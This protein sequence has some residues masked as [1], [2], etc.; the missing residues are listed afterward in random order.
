MM[1]S[2]AKLTA[3]ILVTLLAASTAL[4][5][6]DYIRGSYGV[7]DIDDYSAFSAAPTLASFQKLPRSR[8][9]QYIIEAEL[10]M[11][12]GI[13]IAEKAVAAVYGEAK[14]TL[15]KD[16][17]WYADSEVLRGAW[18][19]STIGGDKVESLNQ[20]VFGD[21][22]NAVTNEK[23]EE[24]VCTLA[25]DT[26]NNSNMAVA[27]LSNKIVSFTSKNTVDTEAEDK[28]DSKISETRTALNRFEKIMKSQH[29]GVAQHANCDAY[30]GP[31]K[32]KTL[33]ELLSHSAANVSRAA[34][35][36][37]T[38]STQVKI[39]SAK[40]V[41]NAAQGKCTL[42]QIHDSLVDGERVLRN[43]QAN[44][45]KT[46]RSSNH[47]SFNQGSCRFLG[48]LERESKTGSLKLQ[49]RPYAPGDASTDQEGK[50]LN[51]LVKNIYSWQQAPAASAIEDDPNRRAEAVKTS[52]RTSR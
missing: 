42:S 22:G 30:D 45:K 31:I 21:R 20:S 29:I 4:S 17:R 14:P 9:I 47:F 24:F 1:N 3:S 37:K 41:V 19:D 51:T 18:A 52:G 8:Q 28:L 49:I 39:E 35:E 44:S 15:S 38:R 32:T 43:A 48:Q 46:M 40:T 33:R 50:D 10:N 25:S 36:M 11:L 13:P 34:G 26:L 5:E 2:V 23:L 16:E 12:R 7:P 27:L 6:V